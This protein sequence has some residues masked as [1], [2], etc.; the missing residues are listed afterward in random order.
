MAN[1]LGRAKFFPAQRARAQLA[2]ASSC[3]SHSLLQT[4][5]SSREVRIRVV[6]YPLKSNHGTERGPLLGGKWSSRGS[7]SGSKFVSEYE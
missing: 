2:F 5:S 4:R 1:R 3:A 7:P 6:A